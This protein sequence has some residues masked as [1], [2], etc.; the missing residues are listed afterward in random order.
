MLL[1]TSR[2]SE[3]GGRQGLWPHCLPWPTRPCIWA[4]AHG[5][6]LKAKVLSWGF[7]Q[8]LWGPA[9]QVTL[10]FTSRAERGASAQGQGQ[11]GTVV[12]SREFYW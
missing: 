4:Q 2:D 11:L 7:L 9:S 5:S 12:A 8:T 10:L 3:R 1:R 6:C